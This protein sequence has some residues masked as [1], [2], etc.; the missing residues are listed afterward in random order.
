MARNLHLSKIAIGLV[1]FLGLFASHL[2]WA[3]ASN[4]PKF[5]LTNPTNFE[6]TEEL[7]VIT[8]VQALEMSRYIPSTQPPIVRNLMGETLPTQSDDL[9]GDGQWDEIVFLVSMKANG[10]QTY[11]LIYTL[12]DQVPIFAKRTHARLGVAENRDKKYKAA[13]TEVRPEWW[14]PQAQ[15]PRYQLEG[16]GWENEKV[17]FR[18]YFDSRNAM[19]IFGKTTKHFV[20]DSI[21]IDQDYHKLQ[22]WG[23]D[24]LKVGTS[25]GAGGV[26]VLIR[27]SLYRL[28]DNGKAKFSLVAAG[29]IRACVKLEYT[30]WATKGDSQDVTQYVFIGPN[31]YY[32]TSRVV[33]EASRKMDV[34]AVG[35]VTMKLEGAAK[36][37]K[38]AMGGGMTTSFGKQSENS[39]LLGMGLFV[40]K[41]FHKAFGVA[42]K[43][44][45]GIVNSA[46]N[47]GLKNASNCFEYAFFAGWEKSAKEFETEVG[48][49]R[50]VQKEIG[51]LEAPIKLSYLSST[52]KRK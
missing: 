28:G 27:D 19:D 2:L 44:G 52:N 16:P 46:L 48:F 50:Y 49:E 15:P 23:M 6:R 33:F 26:G 8:R 39:D 41:A 18:N 13:K 30:G 14:T 22:T 34:P 29:P 24:I 36:Q 10:Q 31:D 1:G 9:D 45:T 47:Y 7:V 21:G 35:L 20:L 5:I 37:T 11:Q 40:P 51:K 17:A 38:T 25:L 32:Y 42:P 43:T 12:P 3:Q 4:A